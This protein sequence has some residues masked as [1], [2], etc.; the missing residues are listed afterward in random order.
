MEHA[1]LSP[2]GASR[3]ATCPASLNK[4]LLYENKTNPQAQ[5]GT[6]VHDL[7]EKMLKNKN[8][9]VDSYEEEQLEVASEY[10]DYCNSVMGKAPVVLI[11]EKFDLSCISPNTFGTGDCTILNEDGTLHV[12]DLKTGRNLVYADNNWQ[13]MLYGIGA[14]EEL[15]MLYTI[16]SVK[17][18]I[19]Q[20]RVGHIDTWELS[21]DALM[22]FKEWIIGRAKLALSDNAPF[23]P[24][25]KACQYCPHQQN[26][27]AL[28]EHVT[29]VITGDFDDLSSV[30]DT[31]DKLST[32]RIKNILD[33]ANL[34]T[35]FVSAVQDSAIEKIEAGDNIDGYKL[36][37]SRTNRKWSDVEEV[38]RY[39]KE[40]NDGVEYY[41]EPELLPMGKILKI[42]NKDEGINEFIIKPSGKTTLAPITDKRPAITGVCDEFEDID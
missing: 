9:D 15:K 24:E 7:G 2:S 35:S 36:V 42:L 39:L 20:N 27:N 23:N 8:I 11:E 3:W 14:I 29:T 28:Y 19:V 18:H 41:K 34:I 32:Q 38:Q 13:L 16:T 4:S 26:C 17:L 12:I 22:E 40:R 21:V 1:K 6:V 37:E 30:E 10:A 33:N 25:E 5:W 31:T